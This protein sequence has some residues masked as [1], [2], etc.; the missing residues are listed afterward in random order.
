RAPSV[1]SALLRPD[2]WFDTGDRG[3]ALSRSGLLCGL[4]VRSEGR[5]MGQGGADAVTPG[6]S[7]G[8]R[9]RRL[10]A[11]PEVFP[12]GLGCMGMSD[13]YGAAD[14]RESIATIHA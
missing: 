5:E 9:L 4:C 3:H 8:A 14:E 2:R 13:M 12:I 1:G 11:G 6:A 7:P 10:G